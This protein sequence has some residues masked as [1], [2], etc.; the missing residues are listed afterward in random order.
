V[1]SGPFES[2]RA[3]TPM[4]AAVLL[5]AI[6][7][8]T[9][10]VVAGRRWASLQP[11]R[12][13]RLRIAGALGIAAAQIVNIVYWL[14]PERLDP[15]VSLPLHV[16]DLIPWVAVA[17]L[18]LP[19]E[20]GRWTRSLTYFWGL[21]LSSWGF[22]WPVLETG[23]ATFRFWLFWLVHLQ[24]V[25][26]A[27]YLVAATPWRPRPRDLAVA[28]AAAA[29]YA[30]A[31]TPVNLALQADYGY[32]G[33]GDGPASILGPWPW[34]MPLLLLG[35]AVIFTALA[36]PWCGDAVMAFIRRRDRPGRAS[37]P[38]PRG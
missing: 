30:A 17:A 18:L 16:C 5:G 10:V 23:P 22:F 2:F 35:E 9:P 27:I 6:T 37:S 21:G 3:F 4:H 8:L 38:P 1:T 11:A 31:L 26:A 24:V 34:R 12:E 15:A 7:V 25:G 20:R 28:I 13:R 19:A 36:W 14:G 29:A 33:P 32:V